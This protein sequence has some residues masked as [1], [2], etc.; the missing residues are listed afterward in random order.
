MK[1]KV[2]DSKGLVRAL[3][4]VKDDVKGVKEVKDLLKMLLK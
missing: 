4:R 3:R 1:V 2:K